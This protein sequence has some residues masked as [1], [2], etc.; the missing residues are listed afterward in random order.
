M[1]WFYEDFNTMS[2]PSQMQNYVLSLLI[3]NTF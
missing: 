3:E 2:T 1:A